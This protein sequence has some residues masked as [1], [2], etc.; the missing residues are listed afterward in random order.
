MQYPG[1]RSSRDGAVVTL[2]LDN[3]KFRAGL[4]RLLRINRRIAAAK[5]RG[6]L[7]GRLRVAGLC[8]AAVFT[9]LRVYCLPAKSNAL[10]SQSRMQPAW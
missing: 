6:G 1:L 3:P 9:F 8:G 5:A 4:D 7:L 2:D 10:P